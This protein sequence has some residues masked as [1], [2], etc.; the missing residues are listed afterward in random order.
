MML[1][2]QQSHQGWIILLPKC[3]WWLRP[4]I[5][6]QEDSAIWESCARYLAIMCFIEE[7][8]GCG[9]PLILKTH[10]MPLRSSHSSPLLFLF[11]LCFPLY[12]QRCPCLAKIQIEWCDIAKL[13]H[14]H[15]VC[16]ADRRVSHQH[17]WWTGMTLYS[18]DMYC[19]LRGL[20]ATFHVKGY[21]SVL[22][23]LK[24]VSFRFLYLFSDQILSDLNGNFLLQTKLF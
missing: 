2:H 19:L 12:L 22:E 24:G 23:V 3:L 16:P 11:L 17:T 8:R 5:G 15:A 1:I 13:Q 10:W 20:L 14:P 9:S 7:A 6:W 21:Y 18:S 4:P